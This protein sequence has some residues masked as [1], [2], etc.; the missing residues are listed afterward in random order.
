MANIDNGFSI[1][2][3]ALQ[4]LVLLTAGDLD[5][6]VAGYEAPVGSL[7]LSTSGMAYRKTGALD[8]DWSLITSG[9]VSNHGDLLGLQGGTTGEY[10]HFTNT[11]HTNILAHLTNTSNPHSTSLS[12][13]TD[14]VISTPTN[15]QF[16]MYEQ[17]TLKWKNTSPSTADIAPSTNRNYVTDSQLTVIQ[18]TSG[19]NTGDQSDA[20]L[21]FSDITTNDVSTSRH[22]FAPK[23]PGDTT[24]FLNG[25]TGSWETAV[26]NVSVV[27]A[28]GI[29]GS[30]ATS[31]TTPAITLTLGAITP[32]SVNGVVLSGTATPTLSVT[33]T[34]SVSGT[35]TGDQSDATLTFSDITTNNSTTLRHGFL[36]KLSGAASQYLDGSGSWSV[37]SPRSTYFHSATQSF[38][39]TSIQALAFD[40]IVR[41]AAN[42]TVSALALNGS[43]GHQFTFATG[44]WY[45]ILV[46]YSA[47]YATNNSSQT[48]SWE[49]YLDGAVVTSSRCRTSVRSNGDIATMSI[50]TQVNIPN[51]G[52]ISLRFTSSSAKALTT[53]ANTGRITFI[54]G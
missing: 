54:A 16:L 44:G 35:N 17:A 31:T 36:P 25:G 24:R 51:G 49:L 32:T 22:G 8:T 7:Y 4:D 14:V 2:T 40:S 33:G 28:N 10:Y 23:A 21:I 45:T 50:N 18:N 37:P 9:G 5:P 48:H 43:S 11:Q 20:T 38:A 3:L 47:S 52:V 34:T 42:I 27:T 13:L 19:V 46:D 26:T 29:S 53:I 1:D 12:N 41:S 39:T 30:V 15:R 6:S